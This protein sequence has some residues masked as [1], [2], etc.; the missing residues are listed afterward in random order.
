[1]H[2]IIFSTLTE[3][4]YISETLIIYSEKSTPQ[5]QDILICEG[6]LEVHDG[7]VVFM[8]LKVIF[9]YAFILKHEYV[10]MMES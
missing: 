7:I 8:I 9:P 6:S 4:Y 1:M 5:A 3:R 10:S 2:I